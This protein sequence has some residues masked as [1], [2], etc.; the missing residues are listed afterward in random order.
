MGGS[1]F[2]GGW[3]LWGWSRCVAGWGVL[4]GIAGCCMECGGLRWNRAYISIM[5]MHPALHACHASFPV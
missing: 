5:Q 3:R 1:A 4:C 2:V